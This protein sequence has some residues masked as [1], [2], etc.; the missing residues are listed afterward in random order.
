MKSVAGGGSAAGA[1]DAVDVILGHVG[2][3]EI[4]DV[5]NFGDVDAAGGDIGGDQHAVLAA[6]EA[7]DGGGPL[8]LRAIAMDGDAGDAL[9][10]KGGG[11]AIGAVLGAGEDD[12]GIE[13]SVFE[14]FFQQGGFE[15]LREVGSRWPA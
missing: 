15:V 14:E 4:D 2:T 8:A 11:E 13:R 10:R 3:I 1:A 9:G 6:F 7:A 12:D 5:R